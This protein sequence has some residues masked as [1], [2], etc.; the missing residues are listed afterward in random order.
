[1]FISGFKT[2]QIAR[3]RHNLK[4]VRVVVKGVGAGRHV[5][6]KIICISFKKT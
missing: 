1:M 6:Y 2:F 5:R 3:R 4:N